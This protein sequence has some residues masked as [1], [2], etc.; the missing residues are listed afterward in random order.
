MLWDGAL[1]PRK[2]K[3]I[4]GPIRTWN[5]NNGGVRQQIKASER[6]SRLKYES[7]HKDHGGAERLLMSCLV[8]LQMLCWWPG[9]DPGCLMLLL[10]KEIG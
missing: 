2:R 1:V 3:M 4:R 5:P 8:S 6:M 10:E 9:G 7:I